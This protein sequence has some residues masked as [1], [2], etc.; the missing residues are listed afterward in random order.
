MQERLLALQ[1]K[2]TG[3]YQLK[4]IYEIK[5]QHDESSNRNLH[6]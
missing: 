2:Q 3:F 5:N 4:S 1:S 6:E